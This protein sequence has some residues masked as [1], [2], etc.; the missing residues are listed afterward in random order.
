MNEPAPL[1]VATPT[2][3][4]STPTTTVTKRALIYL[5]VSTVEQAH[6]A[7]ST[8]GYSI[9]AQ[10]EACE[11]KAADLGAVVVAEFADRGESAKTTERA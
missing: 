3:T 11:R 10:R 6:G 9:P 1:T 4:A 5:R 2:A 8:E 7:D